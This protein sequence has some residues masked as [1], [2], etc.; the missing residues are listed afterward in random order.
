MD[1]NEIHV[2]MRFILL[3][4][5]AQQKIFSEMPFVVRS[6]WKK[7]WICTWNIQCSFLDWFLSQNFH[8]IIVNSVNSQQSPEADH[9]FSLVKYALSLGYNFKHL[10]CSQLYKHK[11][12]ITVDSQ[13]SFLLRV[14]I[15]LLWPGFVFCTYWLSFDMKWVI[16]HFN[17]WK[18]LSVQAGIFL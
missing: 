13:K 1:N 3:P 12:V 5:V 7:N 15:R 6:L 9:A 10:L 16:P 17:I 18:A 8:K 11:T 4:A 14:M 2:Y